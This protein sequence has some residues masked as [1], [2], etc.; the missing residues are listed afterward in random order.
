MLEDNNTARKK[1]SKNAPL[2][3]DR[4]GMWIYQPDATE[5]LAHKVDTGVVDERVASQLESLIAR[6]YAHLPAAVPLPLVEQFSTLFDRIWDA[7]PQGLQYIDGD[8]LTGSVTVAQRDGTVRV[9]NL[10]LHSANGPGLVFPAP[11][12]RLLAAVYERPPVCFQS[13]SFRHGS[14]QPIHADTAYLPLSRDPLALLASWTALQDVESGSG[15]LI[16]YE[17]SHKI[18]EFLF[19]GRSKAVADGPDQHAE[20]LAYLQTE[21]DRR[22]LVRRTFKP[23]KG[24]V[25]VWAADLAHGGAKVVRPELLRR[26]FVCHFM[27]LGTRPT[28]Y[29]A[30]R[31]AVVPYGRAFRLRRHSESP[32]LLRRLAHV[33][34]P[35][36]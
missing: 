26:S 21:C 5:I 28:F 22:G 7:P 20:F 35:N 17:G 27:P 18:P 30:S 32:S 31:E 33:F 34:T 11:V 14:Q 36:R 12:L 3:S 8:G 9:V 13:M 4:A 1:S 15:E 19:G 16:Y 6:G 24:D 29:D 10:H 25:L 2:P 23:R